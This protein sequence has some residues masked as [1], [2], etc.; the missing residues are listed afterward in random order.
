MW[1]VE[2]DYGGI[3]WEPICYCVSENQ[4]E[5]VAARPHISAVKK[6]VRVR[7]YGAPAP[8]PLRTRG[9]GQTPS[10]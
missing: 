8:P 5:E 9:Y 7:K 2:I 1:I 10:R 6:P 3:N 4:A